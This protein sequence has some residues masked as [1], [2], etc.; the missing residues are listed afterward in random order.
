MTTTIT[1]TLPEPLGEFVAEQM[2]EGGYATAEEYIQQLLQEYQK[3]RVREKI[4]SLLLA[5]LKSGEATKMTKE[6]WDEL[7]RRI[8]ERRAK[9]NAS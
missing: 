3:K 6:D 5:G 9:K 4:D 2:A 7:R 8:R 1:I